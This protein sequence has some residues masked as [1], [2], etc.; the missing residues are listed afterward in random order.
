[1]KGR[2]TIDEGYDHREVIGDYYQIKTVIFPIY[3][4]ISSHY[5]KK[6]QMVHSST[7]YSFIYL[8]VL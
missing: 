7:V 3:C 1:M 6:V 8:Y 5:L 4:T 2:K